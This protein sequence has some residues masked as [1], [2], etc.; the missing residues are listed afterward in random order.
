VP[1]C[2]FCCIAPDDAW[3]FSEHAVALPHSEPF[4]PGHAVVAPRRHVAQFYDL[5][6]QEQ[7][8]VWDVVGAVKNLMSEKLKVDRF[9]IGFADF[10]EDEGHMHIHVVPCGPGDHFHLPGGIEWVED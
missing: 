7:R 5:D 1:T 10:P 3:I 4:T 2:P 6:V 9:H 8:M